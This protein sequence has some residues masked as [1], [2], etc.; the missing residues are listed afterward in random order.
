[1]LL[2]DAAQQTANVGGAR[3]ALQTRRRMARVTGLDYLDHLL[4]E[5]EAVLYATRRHPL[6]LAPAIALAVLLAVLTVATVVGGW[7]LL[8]LGEVALLGL[9]ALAL[10]CI[11][12]AW[13]I[14]V[15]Q[16]ELY[17]VTSRRVMQLRG[18]VNKHIFDSSLDKV[19]DLLLR[20]PLLGRLFNFGDLDILTGSEAGINRFPTISRPLAFKTALLNAKHE[21][22]R[23]PSAA[24]AAP[25]LEPTAAG[26]PAGS[27]T[28]PA[29]L[30]VSLK[31]LRDQDLLS[32]EEYQTKKAQI[33]AR[34]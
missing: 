31:A 5:Q 3:A 18:V 30:L 25:A 9:A 13:R 26:L 20:Q 7:Y 4:G 32:E 21:L 23:G 10:P 17:V 2:E 24:H 34:L 19:N 11:W 14:V 27:A 1:M 16:N 12:L 22:E 28:D 29:S 6:V 8:Q 33:L 15:W